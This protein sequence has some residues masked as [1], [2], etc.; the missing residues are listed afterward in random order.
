M[1]R[2]GDRPQCGARR[3]RGDRAHGSMVRCAR[4][5]CSVRTGRRNWSGAIADART[6]FEGS[7]GP[8]AELNASRPFTWW[9][10]MG[11]RPGPS[12]V[13]CR[14]LMLFRGRPRARGLPASASPQGCVGIGWRVQSEILPLQWSQ[15][16]RRSQTLPLEPG[17]SRCARN[18]HARLLSTRVTGPVAALAPR[19]AAD[20]AIGMTEGADLAAR[21]R[22]CPA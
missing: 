11:W 22:G 1:A 10:C 12:V 9:F 18:L 17:A 21:A 15:V 6:M 20:E 8:G 16:D 2:S 14:R 7:G 4:R 19:H 5:G 3:R 13:C